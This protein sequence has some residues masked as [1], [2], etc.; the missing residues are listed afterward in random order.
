MLRV[1]SMATGRGGG[2]GG[3]GG[4]ILHTTLRIFAFLTAEYFYTCCLPCCL[5]REP[6]FYSIPDLLAHTLC[7]R[8]T[9]RI[10]TCTLSLAARYLDTLQLVATV[11]TSHVF[12]LRCVDTSRASLVATVLTSHVF[13]L[14]C[15]D[16]SRAY[17]SLTYNSPRYFPWLDHSPFIH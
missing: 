6:P 1:R 3:F 4:G 10:P 15:V 16:T 12:V 9:H 13:E 11:V 2:K 5:T 7:T 17:H 14:R 8:T